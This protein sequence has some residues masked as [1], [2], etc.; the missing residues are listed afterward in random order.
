M[1]GSYYFF[2]QCSA[3]QHPVRKQLGHGTEISETKF[4]F[5]QSV[6]SWPNTVLPL[7]GGLL[8][9]IIG[10]RKS[11]MLFISL[12]LCGQFIFTMSLLDSV[13]SYP[14]ALVGRCVFGFGGESLN[15][16]V[17]ALIG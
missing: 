16:A 15:V 2:D 3:S 13:R 5:L 4:G 9:D 12:V 8:I 14:L 6:Y 17:L 10:I 7:F 11:M 1:F